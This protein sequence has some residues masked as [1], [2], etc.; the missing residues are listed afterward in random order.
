MEPFELSIAQA[1]SLIESRQL[2]IVELVESLVSRA[3]ALE[4]RLKVW[5]TFEPDAVLQ[6]ARQKQEEL[7]QKDTRGLLH[8]VSVGVKDIFYTLGVKTTM[9]SPVYA[10]YMPEYDATSVARLKSAGAMVMGKTV[11]TEF[12]CMDPPTT[13]NPWNEAHTPGGSSSGSAVGVAARI[14]PA[15]L[16]SQTGGSVTRP[17]SYNGVV[18]M[19]PTFGRISRY[20]VF[21]V[22][23][24][25]DTV[26]F[27]T[28]TVEDA[29]FLLT[30]LAGHDV[31]DFS[32]ST[33]PVSDYVGAVGKPK[34][35]RIGLLRQL[36]EGRADPEVR[37]HTEEVARRLGR[38]GASVEEVD[39]PADFDSLL[40]GHQVVM[41][42]EAA[43]VHEDIFRRHAPEYSPKLKALVETGLVTPAVVYA[44]ALCIQR[45]FRRD[46]EEV[47]RDFDAILTPSTSSQAP[48]DLTTTGDP[49]FQRPWTTSGF[50]TISL[51]SGL[52]QAGLPL[53]IQLASAPF[54]EKRLI[55]VARWCEQVLDFRLAPPLAGC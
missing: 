9:G 26:G 37:E 55:S 22:A 30:A 6:A 42:V 52:S 36:F 3:V 19:K 27:F 35:P 40:A 46:M 39:T 45:D 48:G 29:A 31:D 23:S 14:F 50:P 32:S 16:G 34:T 41:S 12:A 4:P 2:S 1:V 8:G 53:S 25:L 49:I 47:V 54:A 7:G 11:T 13:R 28:R 17:A 18:G 20:G 5:V 44:Q 43:S 15:A 24:S 10:D 21:P 38:S 33:E 51:P